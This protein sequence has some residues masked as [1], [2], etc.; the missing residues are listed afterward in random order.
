MA[1]WYLG[2]ALIASAP[3]AT[4]A[5]AGW[6]IAAHPAWLKKEARA[7]VIQYKNIPQGGVIDEGYVE[8][9]LKVWVTEKD[10]YVSGQ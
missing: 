5:L 10:E 7:S 9:P 4:I 6:D 3:L 1:G 2:F 8:E